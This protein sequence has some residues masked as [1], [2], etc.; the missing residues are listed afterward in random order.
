MFRFRDH[1]GETEEAPCE[2][3]PASSTVAGALLVTSFVDVD[4]GGVAQ[5]GP[6][7]DSNTKLF[8]TGGESLARQPPGQGGEAGRFVGS[9]YQAGP[10]A[11]LLPATLRSFGWFLAGQAEAKVEVGREKRTISGSSPKCEGALGLNQL[12]ASR[13]QGEIK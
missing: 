10:L 12:R 1:G 8:G 11:P 7:Q 13:W 4:C 9:S 3:R 6:D 5:G 2:V